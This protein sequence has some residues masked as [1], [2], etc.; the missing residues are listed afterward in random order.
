MNNKKKILLVVDAPGPAEL[1]HP[2]VPLLKKKSNLLI[3]L[4][5][6]APAKILGKYKHLRCDTEDGVEAI[7]KKFNPD[8][9]AVSISSLVLGPY[10][11]NKFTKLA[12]KNKKSTVCFQDFWANH[13]WPMNFKMLKYWQTM[14]VPDKLAKKYLLEDDYK[15]KIIITGNPAYERFKKIS[16]AEKRK[17]MRKKLKIPGNK[18]VFLYIGAGTPE[19]YKEDAITFNF[20]ADTLQELKKDKKYKDLILIC[21]SHP[22][23]EN[24]ERYKKMAPDLNILDALEINLADEL[25]PI[26][27][28]VISMYAT[29]LIHCC[30]LRIPAISILLPNAGKE[31]LAKIS[32]ND[33]PP[34]VFGAT[35]GI[36]K[37]SKGILK[38]KI[39]K[40]LTD[41]K[42]RAKIKQVQK[43]YFAF[44]KDS[45]AQK[46]LRAILVYP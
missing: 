14:L 13:R 42:Y 37:K 36:Y 11:A 15:G 4:V 45:S 29:N 3:I 30:Y 38:L 46:I 8:I 9:L 39:E 2:V 28:V 33:F 5:R 35:I 34:N 27:D 26:A 18:I 16:V 22:R 10:V 23:D 31:M 6:E 17:R 19:A 1:I 44:S 7:Y 21:H 43:K 24:P 32:L 20:F 40:I 41:K 25:L 12:H